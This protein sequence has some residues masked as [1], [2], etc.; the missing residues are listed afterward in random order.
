MGWCFLLWTGL[1]ILFSPALLFI[2]DTA[3]IYF[4]HPSYLLDTTT[5]WIV[6]I[7]SHWSHLCDF[8]ACCHWH[9][10]CW[11]CSLT[12]SGSAMGKFGQT[13][14]CF[15]TVPATIQEEFKVTFEGL[16]S[17]GKPQ[18]FRGCLCPAC[19]HPASYILPCRQAPTIRCF[20]HKFNVR[21]RTGT[22]GQYTESRSHF[23]LC[24]CSDGTENESK[25]NW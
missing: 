22:W 17:V 1:E 9:V 20:H 6:C 11:S 2:K 25:V 7:F 3:A 14:L 4:P 21:I 13:V 5:Y 23:V 18:Y 16:H 8:Q 19:R 12:A 10:L 15:L 24:Y